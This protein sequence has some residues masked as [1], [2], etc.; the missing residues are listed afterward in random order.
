MFKKLIAFLGAVLLLTTISVNAE[1]RTTEFKFQNNLP[2]QLEIGIF[3]PTA[4]TMLYGF[5]EEY[6]PLVVKSFE[7]VTIVLQLDHEYLIAISIK[8]TGEFMTGGVIIT[9][10]RDQINKREGI[11]PGLRIGIPEDI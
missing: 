8:E 10:K 5:S 4:L 7:E 1:S 9:T 11:V 6:P 2:Y 3:D